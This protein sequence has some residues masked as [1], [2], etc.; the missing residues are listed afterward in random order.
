VRWSEAWGEWVL[1]CQKG[2]GEGGGERE[3]EGEGEGETTKESDPLEHASA[4][5]SLDRSEIPSRDSGRKLVGK[6]EKLET[7]S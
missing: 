3:G 5:Q 6:G 1:D 2:E 4:R 7:S